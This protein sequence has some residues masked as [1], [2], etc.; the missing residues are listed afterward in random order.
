MI[1]DSSNNYDFEEFE[2]ETW[3]QILGYGD[4]YVSNY[5]RVKHYLKTYD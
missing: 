4:Y 5:G 1:N 3:K 2:N